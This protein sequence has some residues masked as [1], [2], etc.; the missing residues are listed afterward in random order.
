MAGLV[1]LECSVHCHQD[2]SATETGTTVG[3][4]GAVI[5]EEGELLH[6][7]VEFDC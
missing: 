2:T 1:A 3:Q 4:Y 7:G 5:G 6:E